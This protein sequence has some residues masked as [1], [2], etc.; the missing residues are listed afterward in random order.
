MKRCTIKAVSV[1]LLL[2]TALLALA[3]CGIVFN[4]EFRLGTALI[5]TE[6]TQ[7][8]AAV[9][10]DANDKIALARIDELENGQSES[11][12]QKGAKY[13]MLSEYGS[14]LAEWDEQIAHLEHELVGMSAEDVENIALND[15]GKATDA[16]ITAGCT[17]AISSYNTA[18]IKAIENAKTKESF[19]A[20][21][22]NLALVM[23]FIIG[24][25]NADAEYTVAIS[26]T[27]LNRGYVMAE[28]SRF[29]GA[30]PAECRLGSATVKTE[31][32]KIAAAVIIDTNN[33]IVSVKIDEY[34][35]SYDKTKKE[36]G[37]DYGMYH[38]AESCPNAGYCWC[39]HLA[40]WDKQIEHLESEL[41]GRNAE[42]VAI[43]NGGQGG[44]ADIT[45]GCTVGIDGYTK[46]VIKAIDNAKG[47]KS[48]S[49]VT[50]E[51]SIIL[52]MD[53]KTVE[54]GVE[55][56]AAA[57]AMKGSTKLAESVV[58]VS[59]PEQQ[60]SFG[61]AT[62]DDGLKQAA[63]TVVVDAEGRIVLVRI[64]EI[65]VSGGNLTSK[66]V[67]GTGYGM[68]H[69]AESCPN[70]AAGYCWASH[71][72]EW[73]DQIAHFESCIVGKNAAEVTAIAVG[74]DGKSTDADIT[75]GCTVAITA[76]KQAVV[77]AINNATASSAK[78][79]FASPSD[80]LLELSLTASGSGS[81]TVS[82]KATVK[83]DA[84]LVAEAAK[85]TQKSAS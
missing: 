80:T 59:A 34:D 42:Q 54:G 84:E 2:A 20:T 37:K 76:Y 3:S 45:A 5:E 69:T 65:D 1:L 82:A 36:L 43:V 12:K 75:A 4:G 74:S 41:V 55:I 44:D 79:L 29:L 50:D 16:D 30:I 53:I 22:D 66:K 9:I 78:K 52:K 70:A 32:G 26:A 62:V 71:L 67:L 56:T 46:A 18:V 24:Y 25:A 51:L 40:E 17:I 13:G 68:Y 15:K 27:A 61:F 73:D 63:A 6:K 11:K 39:S 14:K 48:F 33:R 10:L 58:G 60:L 31:K 49:A 57:A 64:D 83:V 77:E 81:I 85:N 72:G 28:E 8:A 19:G 35:K 38:P 23:N 7:I 47:A 21:V